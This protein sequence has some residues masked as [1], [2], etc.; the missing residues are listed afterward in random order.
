MEKS[1]ISTGVFLILILLLV[2]YEEERGGTMR[3]VAEGR[4]CESKSH[5][6]K[7][8]CASDHNCALVCKN[9]GFSGGHCRGFRRRCFC[10]KHC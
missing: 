10:T 9:E 5:G 2:P 3:M 1:S 7:G 8:P 6:F 4:T